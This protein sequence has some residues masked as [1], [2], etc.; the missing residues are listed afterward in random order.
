MRLLGASSYG[1]SWHLTIPEITGCCRVRPGFY[2]DTPRFLQSQHDALQLTRSPCMISIVRHPLATPVTIPKATISLEEAIILEWK[3]ETGARVEKDDILFEMETDKVVVEVPA[4]VAGC[5]LRIDVAEGPV[6]VN[7][8]VGWIGEAGEM[9]QSA[10]PAEVSAQKATET[11]NVPRPFQSAGNSASPAARR[12]AR[13][14]EIDLGGVSGTGPGGRI[15][16]NDVEAAAA[17]RSTEE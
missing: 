7:Q 13:E 4:P 6:R 2:D 14:L 5:L 15:T 10:R 9:P 17:R 8:A 1:S 11:T 16:E 12:R 3:K